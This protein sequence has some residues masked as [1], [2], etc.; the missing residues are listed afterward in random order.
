MTR[1]LLLL[2]FCLAVS[3]GSLRAAVIGSTNPHAFIDSVDWC[4]FG[5]TGASLPTPQVWTS[6]G[7]RTGFVGNADTGQPFYNLRQ[8]FSWAGNFPS[9]MGLVYNGVS[10]GNTPTQIAVTFDQAENG[11]G[12][13]IQ[14]DS[15]GS[16]FTATISLFDSSYLL[17]GSFTTISAPKPGALF[18][19]AYDT[20]SDVWAVQF[21]ASAIGG[22]FQP[23]FAI[24]TMRLDLVPEPASLVL[25]GSATL[26]LAAIARRHRS[27]KSQ[28]FM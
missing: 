10:F 18:I 28:E 4:Q 22:P 6:A 8:D 7:G 17:L 23:S 21:E 14:T 24:G 19:G 1:H 27:R 26:A 11:A 12:A 5:C 16:P 15:F 3:D 20:V 13:Y 9:G 2:P 25:M